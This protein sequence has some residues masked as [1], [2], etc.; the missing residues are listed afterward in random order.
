MTDA[1]SEALRSVRLIQPWMGGACLAVVVLIAG[2]LWGTR[3]RHLPRRRQVAAPLAGLTLSL[4]GWCAVDVVW[5][6]VA[7]GLGPVVWVWLGL[8]GAGVVQVSQADAGRVR[9]GDSFEHGWSGACGSVQ[10]PVRVGGRDGAV[11]REAPPGAAGALSA[12]RPTGSPRATS[13]TCSPTTASASA[14]DREATRC[15]PEPRR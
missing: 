3:T 11:G 15:E 14:A 1:L 8:T 5:R 9:H 4:V 12:M 7:D 10:G 6:P 13:G 2:A